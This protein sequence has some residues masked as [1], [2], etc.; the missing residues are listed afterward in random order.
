MRA[1]GQFRVAYQVFVQVYLVE[2]KRNNNF[3]ELFS[4]L[5]ALPLMTK[6]TFRDKFALDLYNKNKIL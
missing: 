4:A 3:L 5:H 1:V 2:S 6:P